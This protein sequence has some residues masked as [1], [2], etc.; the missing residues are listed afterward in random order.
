MNWR[1][2]RPFLAGMSLLLA[3]AAA[4]AGQGGAALA[5][6]GAEADTDAGT[7]QVYGRNFVASNG[8]LPVVALAGTPLVAQAIEN[9]RIQAWLPAGI[10]PGS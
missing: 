4:A 8:T 6:T 2:V 3:C 7:I 1:F 9:T 10:V 5:I